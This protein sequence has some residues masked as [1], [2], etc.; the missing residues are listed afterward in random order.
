MVKSVL[1]IRLGL[2]AGLRLGISTQLGDEPYLLLQFYVRRNSLPN[3][4][5]SKCLDS[6]KETPFEAAVMRRQF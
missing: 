3:D 1:H 5:H 2:R 6:G 4:A